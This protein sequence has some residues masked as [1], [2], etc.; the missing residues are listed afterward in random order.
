M[1]RLLFFF[2]MAGML[3]VFPLKAQQKVSRNIESMLQQRGEVYFKFVFPGK[4]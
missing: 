4:Q 1:K 2:L 3:G